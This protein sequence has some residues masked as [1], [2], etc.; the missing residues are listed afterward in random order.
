[1][2]R[3]QLTAVRYYMCTLYTTPTTYVIHHYYRGG[4]RLNVRNEYYF[5]STSTAH[6]RSARLSSYKRRSEWRTGASGYFQRY[7]F[8]H[9]NTCNNIP[10][11]RARMIDV[12]FVKISYA[13]RVA[14]AR[15]RK[16]S[17]SKI[18]VSTMCGRYRSRDGISNIKIKR[19]RKTTRLYGIQVYATT[20]GKVHGVS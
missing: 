2:W 16:Q 14:C 8:A 19:V 7:L 12:S 15:K 9:E 5:H 4:T 18:C 10:I 6:T 17:H 20:H 13:W 11:R 1:M 3:R